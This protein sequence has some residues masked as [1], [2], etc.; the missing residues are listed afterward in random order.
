MPPSFLPMPGFQRP[1][2]VE[3]PADW[4]SPKTPTFS[5]KPSQLRTTYSHKSV[6]SVAKDSSR[7]NDS[8]LSIAE[9]SV[10]PITC[11]PTRTGGGRRYL[12]EGISTHIKSGGVCSVLGGSGAGKTTLLAAITQGQRL[13]GK[14]VSGTVAFNGRPLS[15]ELFQDVGSCVEQTDSLW[16]TLQVG[17]ALEFTAGLCMGRFPQAERQGKVNYLLKQMGLEECRGVI[18]GDGVLQQ[19]IS[20]GQRRRLSIAVALMKRP[21]VLVLDEPT[22]GLDSESAHQIIVLLSEYAKEHNISVLCTI[23]QPSLRTY[24]KFDQLLVL[25]QGRLCYSDAAKDAVAYFKGLQW[26]CPGDP[27]LT[28]AEFILKITNTDFCSQEQVQKLHQEWRQRLPSRGESSS[29]CSSTTAVSD[30]TT[31]DFLTGEH[32]GPIL[33]CSLLAWRAMV[34]HYRNPAVLLGRTLFGAAS[35]AFIAFAYCAARS[36]GQEDI[37]DRVWMVMWLQQLPGF[38]V[39]GTIPAFAHE[40][41]C[42]RRELRNGLFTPLSYIFSD[43]VVSIPLW[44]IVVLFTILPGFVVLKMNWENFLP[45]WLLITAYVGWSHSAAQLCG[46]VFQNAALATVAFTAQTIVNMVFNGTM[47]ARVDDLH[48]SIRWISYIVP[49]RYSFRSGALLEFQG[50]EFAGFK[51]CSDPQLSFEERAGLPCWGEDGTD[52]IQ[53]LS[54]AMFPVLTVKDTLSRDLLVIL[55]WTVC[56]KALHALRLLHSLQRVRCRGEC[57]AEE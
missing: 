50:L 57:A 17:E 55:A 11:C 7:H 8:V 28:P 36:M 26:I 56:A 15:L 19:G 34:G 27:D 32:A 52:V 43:L 10:K 41:L 46:A 18:V 35:V 5:E 25:A 21:A 1:P 22:S 38:L 23:H 54:R 29:I 33:Q 12:L 9:L 13:S 2:D 37:L 20:G 16:P 31:D 30:F 44:F 47:L 4:P 53:A 24:N 49:S 14:K 6:E 42:V 3:R 39:V 40:G 48:E 45:I 51:H